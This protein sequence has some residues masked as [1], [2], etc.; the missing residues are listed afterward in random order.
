MGKSRCVRE[1]GAEEGRGGPRRA[2]VGVVDS[3]HIWMHHET[4]LL[5]RFLVA[6]PLPGCRVDRC[7]SFRLAESPLARWHRTGSRGNV[8]FLV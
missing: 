6:L 7:L 4:P 5:H 2:A 3:Y 1:G 8:R